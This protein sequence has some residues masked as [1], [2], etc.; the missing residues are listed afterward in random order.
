VDEAF[1]ETHMLQTYLAIQAICGWM[2]QEA[3]AGART[4]GA[5]ASPGA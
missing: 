2:T 3:A 5:S 1:L 4:N